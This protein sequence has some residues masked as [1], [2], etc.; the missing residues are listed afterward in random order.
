MGNKKRCVPSLLLLILLSSSVARVASVDY[1]DSLVVRRAKHPGEGAAKVVSRGHGLK[2]L[3][4]IHEKPSTTE[5]SELEVSGVSAGRAE[6]EADAMT[7]ASSPFVASP[8]PI[9]CT[10]CLSG[11]SARGESRDHE[12]AKA[13]N[14]RK[15]PADS[16]GIWRRFL[17][18]AVDVDG[19]FVL[20][21][22]RLED[23]AASLPV[24]CGDS[25]QALFAA[26]RSRRGVDTAE[27]DRTMREAEASY[28]QGYAAVMKAIEREA[29]TAGGPAEMLRRA[30]E[31]VDAFELQVASTPLTRRLLQGIHY[32]EIDN[33]M[34]SPDSPMQLPHAGAPETVLE[35][36]GRGVP[37]AFISLAWSRR[38]IFQALR[39]ILRQA[40][41][42]AAKLR[43]SPPPPLFPLEPRA[44]PAAAELLTQGARGRCT[45]SNCSSTTSGS[46]L[47]V[48]TLAGLA[49]DGADLPSD[50]PLLA[51]E[52]NELA[53]DADGFT[54][55]ELIRNVVTFS[56]KGLAFSRRL[57]WAAAIREEQQ[58]EGKGWMGDSQAAAAE[59]AADT[60]HATPASAGLAEATDA[61]RVADAATSDAAAAGAATAAA[62]TAAA[63]ADAAGAASVG[64]ETGE[65][66]TLSVFIGDTDGDLAGF[67]GADIPIFIGDPSRFF[68]G[69]LGGV[70]LSPLSLL[71]DRLTAAA[72]AEDPAA[73]VAALLRDGAEADAGRRTVLFAA[74]WQQIYNLFFGAWPRQEDTRLQA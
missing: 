59:A 43:P 66:P 4:F 24:A 41:H 2:D 67:L 54:T 50:T 14:E 68:L 39:C 16:A 63:A 65:G 71:A 55:G 56:E 52:A 3:H 1:E 33:F 12:S 13:R 31:K 64:R 72:A 8:A 7:S 60:S 15:Q 36:L 57:R 17:L 20:P 27:F 48:R 46:N 32:T 74:N 73:A 5:A 11:G 18:V 23:Y 51:V 62:D 10:N 29:A 34:N 28:S 30:L 42:A 49:A 47:A 25:T 22:K 38:L 35:L 44:F 69:R 61:L 19:T 21:Q 45:R 6:N 37:V 70:R 58:E 26:C 40:L 53:F 9:A